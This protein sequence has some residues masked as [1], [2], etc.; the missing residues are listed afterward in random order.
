MTGASSPIDV[1]VLYGLMFGFY[2]LLTAA[3]L[4]W[5][6]W[7]GDDLV[8][9]LLGPSGRR[10]VAIELGVVVGLLSV[11]A[12]QMLAGAW[13]WVAR[14]EREIVALMGPLTAPKILCV[15]VLSGV[16]E[17]VFF[18]GAMQPALGLV[19][20]SLLFGVAHT[21]ISR[22]LAGWA[23]F[24]AVMGLVLGGLFLATGGLLAPIVA[25]GVV[26]GVHLWRLAQ[27]TDPAIDGLR[28][29]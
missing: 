29:I 12:T 23:I 2:G 24:A 27:E 13:G 25:H 8:S 17:E 9:V 7:R 10:I 22:E 3:G 28:Q 5:M 14:L 26:N 16:G 6:A 11:A 18:R 4:G 20:T 19:A 21:G 15:A 1:R